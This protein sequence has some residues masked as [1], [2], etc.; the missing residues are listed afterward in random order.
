M[1]LQGEY[2]VISERLYRICLY[3][4]KGAFYRCQLLCQS[5]ILKNFFMDVPRF[6]LHPIF[7]L[8]TLRSL[9]VIWSLL[10]AI[11]ASA[12]PPGIIPYQFV[13]RNSEGV[14][15]AGQN[16]VVRFVVHL[17]SLNNPVFEEVH[18]V[19]SQMDGSVAL[20]LGSGEPIS[21]FAPLI[22]N[23][24]WEENIG[25]IFLQTFV[26]V[27]DG[28]VDIGTSELLTVPYALASQRSG[29]VMNGRTPLGIL[30]ADLLVYSDSTS[31]VI[32]GISQANLFYERGEGVTDVEGNFYKS[33]IIQTVEGPIEFTTSNLRTSKLSNGLPIPADSILWTIPTELSYS[34]SDTVD[35][36]QWIRSIGDTV[37]GLL[38]EGIIL[39]GSDT[40]DGIMASD[41]VDGYIR[42]GFPIDTAI[43]RMAYT[44][45][46][47][48]DAASEGF[49]DV[50]G[51]NVNCVT[52]EDST[53]GYLYNWYAVAT[54]AICPVGWHTATYHEFNLLLDALDSN[55]QTLYLQPYLSQDDISEENTFIIPTKRSDVS[56]PWLSTSGIDLGPLGFVSLIN[57]Q[58][59]YSGLNMQTDVGFRY[60]LLETCGDCAY[61]LSSG[62][63][64]TSDQALFG[65]AS[66]C[67]NP[68]IVPMGIAFYLTEFAQLDYKPRDSGLSVRC[69]RD[70]IE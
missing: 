32:P 27:G 63:F 24:G 17:N 60:S 28:E 21:P 53:V 30:P 12:Q 8:M 3:R 39:F 67:V 61:N 40:V 45:P 16:A 57:G 66:D 35:G 47:R 50:A 31:F 23:I 14:A 59:N 29:A 26:D 38:Q 33:A 44:N 4:I 11:V 7:D 43:Q 41:T 65:F 6:C 56:S 37:D 52:E 70:R 5:C 62:A 58:I 46:Y 42:F 19:T 48:V 34:S 68:G 54:G 2:I 1:L 22:Q 10:S 18:W 64:W 20:F 49:L 9:V 36:F 51:E 15:L 69:V 13:L 55:A 25:G